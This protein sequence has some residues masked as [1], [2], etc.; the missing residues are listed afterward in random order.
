MRTRVGAVCWTVIAL[1]AIHGVGWAQGEDKPIGPGVILPENTGDR[2]HS[3]T[4][5]TSN[6]FDYYEELLVNGVKVWSTS[7]SVVTSGDVVLTTTIP[8][9]TITIRDGDSI[10]VKRKIGHI[11][12]DLMGEFTWD[13]LETSVIE[14][15]AMWINPFA[16]REEIEVLFA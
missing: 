16:R 2:D 12:G 5:Y 13:C 7:G 11:A 8:F 9:S 4:V 14:A 15:T 10:D 6:S 3:E 1:F